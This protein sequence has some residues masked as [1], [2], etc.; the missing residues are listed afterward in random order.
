MSLFSIPSNPIPEGAVTGEIVAADGVRLRYARWMPERG[1]KGTVALFTGRAEFIEKYYEV[2][3]ELRARGFAVAIL[4]W[5]GQGGSQRL[6]RNP[7]KGH[8]RRFSDYQ[9]DLDAFAREV[10]LPDCPAPH[11]AIAHSMAGA[12]ML[13]SVV[14]GRRWFDRMVLVAPMLRIDA[15]PMPRLVRALVTTLAW[16]GLARAFVPGGRGTPIT[17]VPFERNRLTSDPARYGRAAEMVRAF[18]QLG[19]G[20]PTNGWLHAAFRA[21][22]QLA[23]PEVVREIRQPLL[24]VA[25]GGEHVVSNPA[26]EHLATRLIAGAQVVVPAARHEILMEQD[27]FRAQFWAAFDAF[28]PGT[29]VA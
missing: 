3:R 13:Q 28:I 14:A 5:R 21:M 29:P 12:I 7:R 9:L 27:F 22:D 10:L 24:M 4:D 23:D 26:I 2:V 6:R 17:E 20:A 18:P 1:L 19:L 15:L 16:C 25:A 8:V 11:F